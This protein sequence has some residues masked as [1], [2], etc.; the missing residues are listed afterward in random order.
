MTEAEVSRNKTSQMSSMLKCRL[1][2][3]RIITTTSAYSSV[4]LMYV[5]TSFV[6]QNSLRTSDS[7][8]FTLSFSF[9]VPFPLRWQHLFESWA[10]VLLPMKSSE[11]E[12]ARS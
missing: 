1:L 4:S 12:K 10:V 2:S 9:L 5:Y 3:L 11:K 7:P 6:D 8:T